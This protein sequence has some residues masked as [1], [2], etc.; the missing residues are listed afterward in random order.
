MPPKVDDQIHK[1][2]G[3][4]IPGTADI[5]LLPKPGKAI[6]M[7]SIKDWNIFYIFEF[8]ILIMEEGSQSSGNDNN[9]PQ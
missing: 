6:E 8:K 2:T 1:Y 9:L 4:P 3:E 5:S 7:E